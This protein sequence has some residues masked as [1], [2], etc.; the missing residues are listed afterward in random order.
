V[1]APGTALECSHELYQTLSYTSNED[2][3]E[4]QSIWSMVY[5][6]QDTTVV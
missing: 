1:I 4:D 2:R 6:I 3:F 5:A